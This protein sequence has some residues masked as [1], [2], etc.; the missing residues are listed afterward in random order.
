MCPLLKASCLCRLVHDAVTA[1][2]NRASRD[3]KMNHKLQSTCICKQSCP[4]RGTGRSLLLTTGIPADNLSTSRVRVY[5]VTARSTKSEL[6]LI[7]YANNKRIRFLTESKLDSDFFLLS[8]SITYLLTEL[9][10]SSGAVNCAALQ[11]PPSPPAFYG[12]RRFNTVFTRAL[13]WS[14]S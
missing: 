8:S 9:S 7:P 14:L 13:H 11:E 5:S 3:M 12:T 1:Y 10:P 4:E 2:N 6:I